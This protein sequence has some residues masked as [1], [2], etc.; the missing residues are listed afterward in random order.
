MPSAKTT[1]AERLAW[2][3]QFFLHIVGV[4]FILSVKMPPV[5]EGQKDMIAM[6]SLWDKRLRAL[7][8]RAGLAEEASGT[9][10]WRRVVMAQL[11]KWGPHAPRTMPSVRELCG[12]LLPAIAGRL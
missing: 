4:G 12:L 1:V 2:Q 9:I 6:Q 7:G 8:K 5:A 3:E 11:H 10:R